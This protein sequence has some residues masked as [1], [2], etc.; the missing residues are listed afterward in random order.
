MPEDAFPLAV[1]QKQFTFLRR[2]SGAENPFFHFHSK[3]HKR[4]QH[5]FHK[6]RT[7]VFS[8]L[9]VQSPAYRTLSGTVWCMSLPFT[10]P[11]GFLRVWKI[12]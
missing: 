4:T 7:Y 3:K 9:L 10:Y 6:M 8:T 12:V 1:S 11:I 5:K 2:N